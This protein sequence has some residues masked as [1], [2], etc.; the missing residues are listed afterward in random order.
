MVAKNGNELGGIA[1]SRLTF[2]YY[3]CKHILSMQIEMDGLIGLED[4]TCC[5]SICNPNKLQLLTPLL[6][7]ILNFNYI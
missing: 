6:N 3:M 2:V 1:L 7:S 4:Q 5:Y